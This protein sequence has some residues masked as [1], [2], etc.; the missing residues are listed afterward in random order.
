[1]TPNP[2]RTVRRALGAFL[3]LASLPLL[4]APASAL[5]PGST[6]FWVSLPDGERLVGATVKADTTGVGFCLY[7][8]AGPW[9]G[10]VGHERE[11]V[12]Q[13]PMLWLGGQPP[14][15]LDHS[16]VGTGTEHVGKGSWCSIVVP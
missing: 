1:V 3:L 7:F 13:V 10:E 8:T 6:Q 15:E 2:N 5:G 11:N 9:P 16:P 14:E 12:Y 4:A